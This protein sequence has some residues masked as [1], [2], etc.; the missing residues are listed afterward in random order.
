[1]AALQN[2]LEKGKSF[3]PRHSP[4][5][6]ASRDRRREIGGSYP[7]WHSQVHY[8]VCVLQGHELAVNGFQSKSKLVLINDKKCPGA[9]GFD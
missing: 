5:L 4:R 7:D 3:P 2:K 8:S 9:D 1:V 6:A